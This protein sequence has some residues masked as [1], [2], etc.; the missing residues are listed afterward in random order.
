[1]GLAFD[2]QNQ[3]DNAISSLLVAE[4]I[5]HKTRKMELFVNVQTKLKS[6]FD[7]HK[8]D[9]KKFRDIQLPETLKGYDINQRQNQIR[10][11]KEK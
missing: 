6:L 5:Y 2:S 11:S 8:T 4:I 7:K 10:T 1:M 3:G 9:R